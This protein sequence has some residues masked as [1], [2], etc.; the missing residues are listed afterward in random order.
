MN[1]S[2][3]SL[4]IDASPGVNPGSVQ[5]L[6]GQIRASAA[7]S[8][9]LTGPV[10]V[11]ITIVHIA[12]TDIRRVMTAPEVVRPIIGEIARRDRQVRP[13][14]AAT[15]LDL[16][17]SVPCVFAELQKGLTGRHGVSQANCQQASHRNSCEPTSTTH[18][19]P[20][21]PVMLWRASRQAYS[22][23]KYPPISS[24]SGLCR[25]HA[26]SPLAMVHAGTDRDVTKSPNGTGIIS[27][28]DPLPNGG[29]SHAN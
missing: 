6:R 17:N 24:G 18:E 1:D 7:I 12:R 2:S 27:R 4:I 22:K 19:I 25:G 11:R 26:V 3:V 21:R 13:W 9:T 10:G 14:A 20:P 8:R 5:G 15:I 28:D 29:C 16:N 23:R